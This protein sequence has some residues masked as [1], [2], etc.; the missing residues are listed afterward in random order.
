MRRIIDVR[1]LL[2][3]NDEVRVYAAGRRVPITETWS[4]SDALRELAER[5]DGAPALEQIEAFERLGERSGA[6]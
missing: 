2:D 1:L 3:R 6:A 4:L 5:I